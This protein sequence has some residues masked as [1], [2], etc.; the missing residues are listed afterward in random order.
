MFAPCN[1]M[2]VLILSRRTEL[3]LAAAN[4][5]EAVFVERCVA[6]RNQYRNE[7]IVYSWRTASKLPFYCIFVTH[8]LCLYTEVVLTN[9]RMKPSFTSLLGKYLLTENS[10]R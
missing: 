3:N 2:S 1:I 4:I 9:F 5:S 7:N 6:G 10:A 8:T